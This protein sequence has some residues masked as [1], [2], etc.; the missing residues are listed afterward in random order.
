MQDRYYPPLNEPSLKTLIKLI[1]TYPDFLDDP[2]CPYSIEIKQFLKGKSSAANVD[3]ATIDISNLT[4][5]DLLNEI[6]GLYQSLQQYGRDVATSG[7]A[8]DK[9]TYFRISTNLLEKI[10]DM[11]EKTLG[12]KQYAAF[13]QEILNIMDSIM[14]ADQKL[15]VMNRLKKFVGE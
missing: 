14:N 11:R 1:E 13:Q 12:M 8:T 7:N 4:E 10:V 5:E 15:E 3:F 9:N 6:N 2:K